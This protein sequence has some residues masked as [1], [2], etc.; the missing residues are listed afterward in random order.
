MV[1][2]LFKIINLATREI[3]KIRAK[4]LS[5][6]I[7]SSGKINIGKTADIINTQRNPAKIKIG[8]GTIIDGIIQLFPFGDGIE[9]GKNCYLGPNSRIWSSN[10]IVIGNSVLISHDVNIIDSNSHEIDYL[11]REKSSIR[12]FKEGLPK[13]AGLVETAPITI[14]DNAWISYNVCILKGVTIGKGAIVGCGSV[15]THDIPDMCLAAGN[16]AK[17]IKYLAG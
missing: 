11:E 4:Y 10:H 2:I 7:T 3:A 14:K 9:I 12:Q 5:T 17:V 13:E 8:E 6:L 1:K 16:P 15:V